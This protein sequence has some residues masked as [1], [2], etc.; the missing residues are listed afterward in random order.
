M[1]GMDQS[2]DDLVVEFDDAIANNLFLYRIK[3][4]KG[5][6]VSVG[7]LDLLGVATGASNVLETAVSKAYEVVKGVKFENLFYRPKFDFLSMDYRSSILNRF[8]AIK[9][10]IE[11]EK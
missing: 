1:E 7:G 10:F 5:E 9:P 4:K 2:E 11:E 6:C 3:E 8:A